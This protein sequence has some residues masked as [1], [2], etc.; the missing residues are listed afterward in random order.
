MLTQLQQ[1]QESQDG[2]SA[3]F[4][5]QQEKSAEKSHCQAGID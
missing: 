2:K 5:D 1:H 3:Q 4:L